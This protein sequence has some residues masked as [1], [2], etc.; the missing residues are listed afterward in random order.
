MRILPVPS[1]ARL[2]GALLF[3]LGISFAVITLWSLLENHSLGDATYWLTFGMFLFALEGLTVLGYLRW[4]SSIPRL[5]AVDEQGI[6]IH[7]R[8]GARVIVWWEAIRR[9]RLLP[10]L[11]RRW[12]LE[13]PEGD[14]FISQRGIKARDWQLLSGRIVAEV[15]GR[16]Y[17]V[18]GTR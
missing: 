9:A 13:C 10:T 11:E 12:R 17:P 7:P 4:R 18:E 8:R 1:I 2:I 16:G 15:T 6:E 5:I 14:V 3:W